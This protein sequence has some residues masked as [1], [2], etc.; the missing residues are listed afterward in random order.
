MTAMSQQ[1][2]KRVHISARDFMAAREFVEAARQHGEATVEH[3]ALL[4]CAIVRYARP[5][6]AN[7]KSTTAPADSRL[8]IDAAEVL[9]D[10]GDL[11]LHRRIVRLRN[12]VVAHSQSEHFPVAVLRILEEPGK[13][14][15][16]FQS[17]SWHVVNERLDLEAFSRIAKAMA[18]KCRSLV[19]DLARNH[20]RRPE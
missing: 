17:R 11:E 2:I 4:E 19:F 12:E 16:I 9:P 18:F 1:T 5:F 3:A 20:G 7:E 8:A 15:V 6:S 10:P 13:W 14:G